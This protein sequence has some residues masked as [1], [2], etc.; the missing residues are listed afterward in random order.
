MSDTLTPVDPI[1]RCA[2]GYGT[3]AHLF[4]SDDDFDIARAKSICRK[5]GRA[6]ACL[7]DAIERHEAYGVWGGELVVD[8]TV[9]GVRRRRGRPPKQPR[10]LLVV[11]EV[12][13]PPHLVA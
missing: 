4:F 9:V 10:Q 6:S 1:A 2:D 12:P 11:D 5:C 13:V 7:A 8:G 3:L